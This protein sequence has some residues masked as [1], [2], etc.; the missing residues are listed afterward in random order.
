MDIRPSRR[1]LKLASWELE[2]SL[3]MPD[4]Q[5][6]GLDREDSEAADSRCQTHTGLGSVGDGSSPT[7][8]REK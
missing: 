5:C 1:Y 4:I 6:Q 7:L 3:T 2:R 8:G